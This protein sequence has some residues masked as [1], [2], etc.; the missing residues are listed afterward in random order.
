MVPAGAPL[1]FSEGSLPMRIHGRIIRPSTLSERR[2]LKALGLDAV[3]VRRGVNPYAVARIIRRASLGG[4]DM[5]KLRAILAPRPEPAPLPDSTSE[6]REGER[7][8]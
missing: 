4:A 8:A 7:A 3:R 6:P 2:V 5:S 1:F